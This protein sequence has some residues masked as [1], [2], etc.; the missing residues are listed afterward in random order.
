VMDE[1]TL[2]GAEEALHRSIVVPGADAVH[3][4]SNAIVL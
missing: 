3:A 4:R 1:L 2:Q